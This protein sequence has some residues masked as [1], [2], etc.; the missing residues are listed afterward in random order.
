MPVGLGFDIHK[1][2]PGRRLLLGGVAIDHPRGL[3]GHSDG[4][5]VL[6]AVVDAL[7]GA[8][9]RGDIG[10]RFPDTDA[11]WKGVASEVFLKSVADEL[12]GIWS[13]E[14]IDVTILAE[15][16]KLGDRKAEIARSVARIAGVSAGA[17]SVKAKTA[18]G[19][20]PIGQREAIACFAVA[21]L[22][23]T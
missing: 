19:L 1:L 2:V 7:L 18:E 3:E 12:R 20:G 9:A 6:H 21:Q 4:D 23:R 15:E 22:S 17:V 14:N 8:T 10:E 16:P 11:R 5:V 13:V